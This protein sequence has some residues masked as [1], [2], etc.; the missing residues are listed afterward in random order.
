M[1]STLNLLNSIVAMPLVY[2]E[3]DSAYQSLLY[4]SFYE[5]GCCSRLLYYVTKSRGAD[6][7]VDPA[8]GGPASGPAWRTW[9]L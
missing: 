8:S 9:A 6:T 4:R 3:D 2:P 5:P 1:E 7:A